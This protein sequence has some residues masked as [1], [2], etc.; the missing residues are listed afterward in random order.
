MTGDCIVCQVV[1][2]DLI[3]VNKERRPV[4]VHSRS[5][6]EMWPC[7]LE[8][9]YAKLAGRKDLSKIFLILVFTGSYYH[10]SGG[11]PMSAMVDFTG[12]FPKVYQ[13]HYFEV[14]FELIFPE[15]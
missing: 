3:P 11:L 14:Y 4:F 10:L 8:K 7:L 5:R 9:A 2:D 12:G 1:V 15:V 6:G 13:D